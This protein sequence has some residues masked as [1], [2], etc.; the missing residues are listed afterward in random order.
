MK[1]G[2]ILAAAMGV[3][4][5]LCMGA[6]APKVY[7]PDNEGFIHN[8]IILEPIALEGVDHV[9]A[10]EKPMFDKQYFKDQLTALPKAEDKVA[11][12]GKDFKW[13]EFKADDFLVDLA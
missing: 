6:D 12:G 5:L 8:W 1:N 10:V 7:K 4:S 11:I 9:E 3:L 2:A 13:H